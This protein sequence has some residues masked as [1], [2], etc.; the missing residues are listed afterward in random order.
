MVRGNAVVR[1][2]WLRQGYAVLVAS[3]FVLAGA[4]AVDDDNVVYDDGAGGEGTAGRP[5][6]AGGGIAGS[7]GRAGAGSG[8][9]GASSSPGGEGGDLGGGGDVSD[10]GAAGAA[11]AN[12]ADAACTDEGALACA[13]PAGNVVL[14]CDDGLW[15]S[16]ETCASG[17]LCD[18]ADPGCSPIAEG[19]EELAP[20]ESFCDGENLKTCGPDRVTVDTEACEGR[21]AGAR[22]VSVTCG[23]G[24]V[25][26]GEGCDDGNQIDTDACPSTCEE[27]SCGDGFVAAANEECDDGNDVDSDDC[28]STCENAVCGDGF[29]QAG[30]EACDDGNAIETDACL[31]SCEAATCGDGEL[32]AGQ[33]T[34]E[35]GNA[36]DT[37]GC[38]STCETARCGD[39]FV[40]TG[41][42]ECDDENTTAGDGCSSTCQTEP[43]AVVAGYQHACAILGDGRLKCWGANA[44]GQLGIGSAE[45]RVGAAADEMGPNLPAVF[46]DGVSDVA[47]GDYHTCAIRDEAV[48]CWGDNVERQLG[49][50]RSAQR[51]LTPVTVQVG[52]TPASICAAGALSAVQLAS[53]QVLAWGVGFTT[54]R[55]AP[56]SGAARSIACGDLLCAV[57]ESDEV[58]C[59]DPDEAT[60]LALTLAEHGASSPKQVDAGTGYACV[61]GEDGD[62]R[63]FGEN[64]WGNLVSGTSAAQ[65]GNLP[66]NQAWP[67]ALVGANVAALS[68]GGYV[69]CAR[70]TDGTAKCWGFG[71]YGV[72]GQP[73]RASI[74]NP[75]GDEPGETASNLPPINLGTAASVKDLSAGS[76]FV[77]A[78]LTTG[79]IRCWGSNSEGQLGIGHTDDIGDSEDE[80]GSALIETMV[81]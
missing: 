32:W 74:G 73:S 6:G 15:A 22:C 7:G 5:G 76:T 19:C 65:V 24:E 81:D 8:G 20:G 16:F 68:V 56:F 27:A 79:T 58:E 37:D 49:P 70:Y 33:E 55:T 53:G 43:V 12:G 48:Y 52:G 41:E 40:R 66:A 67:A 57:L 1:L 21:C 59:W 72:L 3:G 75:L 44:R 39:G 35:D 80:M 26:A 61:L 31:A 60:P 78:L 69:T 18:S 36:I 54:L 42:E 47:V 63:C 62:V 51:E 13:E 28:P 38:P 46:S 11:G 34:C 29:T 23:D 30:E 2:A 14:R 45:A 17:T 71:Y 64:S 10:A 50:G 4:C 25:Q 9:G 77:C